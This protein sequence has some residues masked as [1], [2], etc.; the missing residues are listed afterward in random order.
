[1]AYKME[2]VG[3]EG[4][5]VAMGLLVLPFVILTVLVKLLPTER[6]TPE[7][8]APVIAGSLGVPAMSGD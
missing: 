8:G 4:L 1:M 6:L 3:L 2:V 5:L 7:P